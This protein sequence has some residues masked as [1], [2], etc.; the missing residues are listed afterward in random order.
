MAEGAEYQM[1]ISRPPMQW[2]R[3]PGESWV[4]AD[5]EGGETMSKDIEVSI[6]LSDVQK[7]NLNTLIH[8]MCNESCGANLTQPMTEKEGDIDCHDC[9][10]SD[11]IRHLEGEGE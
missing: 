8:K 1:H 2:E 10:I 7:E 6:E 3:K 5:T 9:P 4:G 11:I